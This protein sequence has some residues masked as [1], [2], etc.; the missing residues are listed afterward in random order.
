MAGELQIR[1]VVVYMK[2]FPVILENASLSKKARG[3][4]H[5]PG[6]CFRQAAAAHAIHKMYRERARSGIDSR[7][8][9]QSGKSGDG[10]SGRSGDE[11]EKSG[12]FLVVHLFD[13]LQVAEQLDFR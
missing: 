4:C 3:Q 8:A 12:S 5:V 7:T 11:L 13:Y 10:N 1:R 9:P 2:I 6:H